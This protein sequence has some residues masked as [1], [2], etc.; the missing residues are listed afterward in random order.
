MAISPHQSNPV[1]GLPTC[2]PVIAPHSPPPSPCPLTHTPAHCHKRSFTGLIE[3]ENWEDRTIERLVQLFV[4]V[5]SRKSSFRGGAPRKHL[6]PDL[7]GELLLQDR[8]S[9]VC[10]FCSSEKITSV[11][12]LQR[13]LAGLWH[14][15]ALLEQPES[16]NNKQHPEALHL[17]ST[18][19]LLTPGSSETHTTVL[20]SSSPSR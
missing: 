14:P 17:P 20:L 12:P 18:T 2:S 9:F 19:D 4:T 13:R 10:F 1:L 5:A 7:G 15:R 8:F 16:Q 6:H 3:L 11:C